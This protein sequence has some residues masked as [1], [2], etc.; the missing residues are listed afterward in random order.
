MPSDGTSFTDINLTG[1]IPALVL[2]D[3]QLLTEGAAMVQYI[4]DLK[5]ESKLAPPAG[6]FERVRMQ[7]W[8]NFIATE[9]H[10]GFTPLFAK[11]VNDAYKKIA[12]DKILSRFEF[13]EGAMKGKKWLTGDT[14]TIADGYMVYALRSWQRFF[15]NEL[16]GEMKAYW[17]RLIDRP[18][19]QASFEAEGFSKA[20]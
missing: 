20:G 2:D 13:I 14:F 5:P 4:A 6:T 9:L 15:K 3:G 7:E 18:S 8:L 1:Y 12:S 16:D 11:D 17:E 10:K 19:V